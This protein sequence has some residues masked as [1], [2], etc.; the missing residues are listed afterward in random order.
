MPRQLKNGDRIRGYEILAHLNTGGMANAFAARS[1]SGDKVF[2]KSYKSPSVAVDWYHGYVKYQKELKTRIE[3]TG[4]RKFCVRLVDQFEEVFGVC[5]FF[6]A[7][8][9]V[10][11]GEDMS[12]ILTKLRRSPSTLNWQQRLILAKVMMAGIHQLHEAKIV[13]GDL[14]PPNLQL[15]KDETIVAGWQ[16]KLIDMDFSILADLRAPWH[17]KAAYVGTPHYFSPEHLQEKVPLPASDVFTCGLI[18]YEL[19]AQGHPYSHLE[20]DPAYLRAAL[21][22]NAA[23]PKLQGKLENADATTHLA[24]CLHRCLSA[25]PAHR[26][27]AREVNLA[28]NGHVTVP[29]SIPT[30]PAP[31]PAPPVPKVTS[32]PT[33][34]A[35]P[36]HVTLKLEGKTGIPL[37]FRITTRVGKALL[38]RFG[39]EGDY[40]DVD[41]FVAEFRDGV[42]CVSPIDTAKN[43]TLL[44]GKPLATLTA[45]ADGDLLN[46]GSRT[47]SKVALPL[48][49]RIS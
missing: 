41:Q 44:N 27:A 19:L 15:F 42:W 17:G 12:A 2:F 29:S 43:P 31:R 25:D 3:S 24:D 14:K 46:L 5:T 47:S 26:P 48:K 36:P 34:P 28:L 45:L 7:F 39:P 40:A 6:Q 4:V 20:D 1:P 9:F 35:K 13:H 23:K 30:S 10:H 38:K 21:K 37:E 18:L 49:V 22:H 8:E 11:G 33:I 32:S 16:L